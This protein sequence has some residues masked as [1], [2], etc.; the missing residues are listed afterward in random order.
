[1]RKVIYL[2]GIGILLLSII[3]LFSSC[4]T[5]IIP[6]T[7]QDET[8]ILTKEVYDDCPDAPAVAAFLLKEAGINKYYEGGNYISDVAREMGP[9]TDFLGWSKCDQR[10]ADAVALFLKG[11]GASVNVEDLVYNV[12]QNKYYGII[13]NAINEAVSGDTIIVCPE[14][15]YENIN[16]FGKDITLQSTNPDNADVVDSTT[17]NGGNKGSVVTF[18]SDETAQAVLCGFT[19]TN[20]NG[21]LHESINR[22][23]GGGIYIYQ[24]NPTIE[25][26]NIQGNEAERGGGISIRMSN[27]TITSNNINNNEALSGSGIYIIEFSSPTITENSITHNIAIGLGGGIVSN[28]SSSY[29]LCSPTIRNNNITNNE[30]S[31]GGGISMTYNASTITGNEINNNIAE[32]VASGGGGIYIVAS[33][34]DLSENE[35]NYNKASGG[36]GI[37]IGKFSSSGYVT[38]RGNNINNNQATSEAGGGGIYLIIETDVEIGGSSDTDLVNFNDFTDNYKTGTSASADQHIRKYD[39][40]LVSI[41]YHSNYPYNNFTPGP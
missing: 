21:T 27:S 24:S 18:L 32:N 36:G 7:N 5:S 30:A 11:Q 28:G 33:D 40:T 17:I 14:T 22:T 8:S 29:N 25:K 23:F 34:C 4:S 38:I 1:M 3:L 9:G 37:C 16:F 20:G 13:Q 10:Y 2:I 19:I 39:A 31:G 6:S 12:T 35:I 15:Y 41:D 26:N